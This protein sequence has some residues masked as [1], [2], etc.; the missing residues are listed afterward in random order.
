VGKIVD[1]IWTQ[2]AKIR[3]NEQKIKGYFTESGAHEMIF[4]NPGVKEGPVD[5]TVNH[6]SV[7]LLFLNFCNE[8]VKSYFLNNC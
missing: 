3:G 7:V 4:Y 5:D 2:E 8:C 1:K 6:I